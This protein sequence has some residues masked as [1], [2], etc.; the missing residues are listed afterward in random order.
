MVRVVKHQPGKR[1]R[2][3]ERS[4]STRLAGLILDRQL[5]P[6]FGYV[7]VTFHGLLGRCCRW[8]AVFLGYEQ[9]EKPVS[10]GPPVGGTEYLEVHGKL[11][12]RLH[13]G[14]L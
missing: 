9:M 5:I 3:T 7:L 13:V 11:Y 4:S 12:V 10:E 1:E 8:I 2:Q 14:R 6:V